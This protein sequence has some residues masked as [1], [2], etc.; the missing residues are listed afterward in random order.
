MALDQG[1]RRTGF[2]S[3]DM[4]AVFGV[5]EH[6]DLHSIW[7]VKIGGLIPPP[8]TWRMRLG[9]YLERAVIDIYTDFTG[10][11]IE[12][13]FDKTY[14]H[15]QFPHVLATP[16]A[17]YDGGGVDAKVSAWD[18]R[19]QWGATGDD[20]PDRVQLQVVTCM[21]VFDKPRWDI[22]L[23]SGDEFRVITMD[24][25][26][27][28]GAYIVSQ[29]EGIWQKF[30]EGGDGPPPIGESKISREWL[31]S[32]Y[33][34]HTP[35]LRPATNEEVEQLRR[36]GRLRAEQTAIAKK[37]YKLE[38]W[39]LDAIKDRE[40][41]VWDGGRFTWRLTKDSHSM[42]WESMALALMTNFVGEE[43]IRRKL[44]ADYS[45]TKPGS[46]RIWFTSDECFAT[47]EDADAT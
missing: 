11:S 35:D 26:P 4:G 27:E 39:I 41:L 18:Q 42:D 38:N 3:T 40:G 31:R 1:L 43:E 37:R 8:A 22:A 29:A 34:K 23:L 36:Y 6:R 12:P 47:E 33:P 14:R 15:P 44:L 20:I 2:T 10:K 21:E 32:T 19:H 45:R 46:R 5:D 9:H 13:L 28:F 25:D 16:D 7:A 30:F 24:R 17:L